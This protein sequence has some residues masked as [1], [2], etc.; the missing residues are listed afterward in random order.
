VTGDSGSGGRGR[1]WEK[2]GFSEYSR[3]VSV[4]WVSRRVRIGVSV[5][6]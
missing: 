3:R 1:E 5:G 2:V 6:Q 4:E